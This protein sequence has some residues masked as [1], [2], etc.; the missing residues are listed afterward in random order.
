[1]AAHRASDAK[2]LTAD[3]AEFSTVSGRGRLSEVKRAEQLA[4]MSEYLGA[5]RFSRYED[6]VVPVIALSEDGSLAW[7]ACEME[8]E[9]VRTLEGKSEPIAYAFSWV[10]H[11]ARGPADSR[12]KRPWSAIGNASSLRP[13]WPAAK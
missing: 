3:A 8:A 6:T 1:M 11:Y 4:R 13:D 12:G 10:E 5:L 2:L 9:G 7:L